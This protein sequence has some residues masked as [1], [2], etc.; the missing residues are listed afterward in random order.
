MQSF[1]TSMRAPAVLSCSLLLWG[2]QGEGSDIGPTLGLQPPEPFVVQV[3][4]DAS[5]PVSA[6]T[7]SSSVGTVVSGRA[8]RA[9]SPVRPNAPAVFTLSAH[10]ASAR[11]G[12]QL[13]GFAVRGTPIDES[14]SLERAIFLP[15]VSGSVGLPLATG[16]PLGATALDDR[17]TS[18]AI[19]AVASGT[20]VSDGAAA[21]VTLRTASLLARH[22]P[23]APPSAN[24]LA[25]LLT[26]AVFVSPATATFGPGVTLSVADS[27]GATGA[28]AAIDVLRLDATTGIWARVGSATA[29]AG[30]I[31]ATPG[32]D[33][34]GLY[35]FAVTTARTCSV[36]GRVVDLTGRP[37]ARALVH[38]H[39]QTAS[40]DT[41]GAFL[42]P[43]LPAVDLGARA[44]DETIEA[45]GGRGWLPVSATL[46]TTLAD[47]PVPLPDLVLDTVLTGHMRVLLVERGGVLP[48]RRVRTNQTL[49]QTRAETFIGTS[50]MGILEDLPAG[51]YG[52]AFGRADDRVNGFRTD[53]LVRLRDNERVVDA[54]LFSLRSGY[55]D[56]RRGNTVVVYDAE[57]GGPLFDVGVVRGVEPERGFA[58]RTFDNGSL[59]VGLGSDDEVTAVTDTARDGRRAIS[60]F[61]TVQTMARR[62]ELPVRVAARA[63]TGA[64]DRHGL[65]EGSVT[66]GVAGRA[67]ELC[68]TWPLTYREWF[69]RVMLDDETSGGRVP[70]KSEVTS[71]A[72]AAFTIGVP[73]PRGH[74]SLA[75]HRVD[76]GR[77]VLDA[78]FVAFDLAPVEGNVE[79]V[80][81]AFAR[82]DAQFSILPPTNLDARVL[83]NLVAD[84]GLQ[85]ASGTVADVARG[86]V[87]VALNLFS[88]SLTFDLPPLT[89][90]LAGARHRVCLRAAA[91]SGGV[92]VEQRQAFT[93]TTLTTNAAA[94]QLAVPTLTSPAPGSL[95]SADGFSVEFTPPDD[96]D[97]VVVRLASDSGG[98]LREWTALLPPTARSFTF[99][100]LPVEVAQVLASGRTWQLQVK[101]FRAL[102]GPLGQQDRPYQTVISTF[103]SLGAAEL[104]VDSL[105]SLSISVSTP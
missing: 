94:P 41:A 2:C 57:G 89:G 93:L 12:D 75:E 56:G 105:A 66:G 74:V 101:A 50:G 52:I 76:A 86:T 71:D 19:L 7:V 53:G 63:R 98:E 46:L 30:R 1:F 44:R 33:G 6:A 24:G 65:V 81:G 99:R 61:T 45:I 10:A 54:R 48:N 37:V 3:F 9:E 43:L 77:T 82:A 22:L 51:L 11:D 62:I 18:G 97:F 85:N 67:R 35:V 104:G 25:T 69:E 29:A 16:V 13:V 70:R 4:D 31:S 39:G 14:R 36:S 8:G 15:D 72:T 73:R 47:G 92:S 90:E 21:S 26:S 88:G 23:V 59:F 58:G 34:G 84:W 95:V 32:I 79:R 102:N 20:V 78:A 83:G 49:N 87:G 91:T 60:A 100:R 40:T 103:V 80:A 68:A 28:A 55:D 5:R 64:F 27:I 38:A 42:L 17:A 96:A